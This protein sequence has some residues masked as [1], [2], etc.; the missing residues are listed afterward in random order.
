MGIYRMIVLSN[1]EPGREKEFDKWYDE[2][3]VGEVVSVPG[4]VT[5]QRFRAT[6]VKGLPTPPLAYDSFAI[7]EI[8]TD[9]IQ[10]TVSELMARN[11]TSA[12]P[13]SE[14]FDLKGAFAMIL[15]PTCE[16]IRK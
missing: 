1:A 14:S 12:L 16:L 7:Y 8:E 3:H 11:G 13:I 9:D 15:E 5:G 10:K 4:F 6:K 2:T